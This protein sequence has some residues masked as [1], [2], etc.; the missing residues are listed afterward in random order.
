MEVG[1][2][3]LGRMG[4]GIAERLLRTGHRVVGYD[5]DPEA[6]RRV[7]ESGADGVAQVPALVAML[8]RPRTLWLMEPPVA[9]EAD[10]IRHEKVK[11]LR[12][13]APIRPEDVVFGQYTRGRIDGH[14]VPGYREESGVAPDSQTETFVALRLHVANWRWQGVP[15]YLVTGKRMPQR[16]TQVAVTFRCPPVSV[17][18]PFDRCEIGPNVLVVTLQPDEG[19]DLYFETKTPGEPLTLQ[20]QRLHFRY[21][22]A[23][24][25]L[26]D[27]YQT[28]LL[29][30]L[31][32]DQ[33]L[34][35]R[36]DEVEASW[37]LYTP[38]LESQIPLHPYPAGT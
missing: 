16:R 18:Q 14:E 12:A 37:R 28:L 6:V 13:V 1:M 25:P 36:A 22:E 19:F 31:R 2:I 4:M 9:F 8:Q 23:F 32:G 26:P 38:I 3:G 29:D 15:F 17:F 24:G 5:R 30:I 11:V 20:T 10:A 7:R 34:F 33:T 21:S 27:A 35:V